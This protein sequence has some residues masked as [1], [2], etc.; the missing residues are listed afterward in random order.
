MDLEEKKPVLPDIFFQLN[1][2]CA[3]P[4]GTNST[5]FSFNVHILFD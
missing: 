2:S 1:E 5:T 4:L 3:S